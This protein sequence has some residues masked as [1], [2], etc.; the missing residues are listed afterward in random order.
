MN[1]ETKATIAYSNSTM[2]RGL[3]F[4]VANQGE[5]GVKFWH[6]ASLPRQ[7]CSIDLQLR[8]CKTV[9]NGSIVSGG[10][11]YSRLLVNS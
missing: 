10:T 11:V 5:T 8:Q 9:A 4:T 2:G 3:L 7:D 6:A 1:L